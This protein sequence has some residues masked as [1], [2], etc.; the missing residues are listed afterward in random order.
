MIRSIF[1]L[2]GVF[3]LAAF[4]FVQ[5]VSAQTTVKTKKATV[6]M[7]G[8]IDLTMVYRNS[9]Y[10]TSQKGDGTP[11]N[12]GI[13]FIDPNTSNAERVSGTTGSPTGSS[14]Y[15]DPNLVLNFTIDV[16]ENVRGVIELRTPF[17]NPDAGGKN[18]TPNTGFF[19]GFK[20]RTLEVKQLYAE[21][22]EIFSPSADEPGQG[23]LLR[24]GIFDFRKDLR[25]NGNSF[26]IDT[27]GSEHPFDSLDGTGA[28]PGYSTGFADSTEAA[29]AY[30]Q[31]KFWLFNI[32]AFFLNLDESYNALGLAGSG[33][34]RRD[35]LFWGGSADVLFGSE[36]KFGKL[37]LTVF[38]LM[39]TS[40]THL[41]TEGAG[42]VVYPLRTEE[43]NLIELFGEVYFQQGAYARNAS[44]TGS[45]VDQKEA[46]ALQFGLKGS[47]PPITIMEDKK[48]IPYIEGTYV[49]VSGDDDSLDD[50]NE[51]FVSLENNNRTIVV[52]NGYYGYDID[53]NYRGVRVAGGFHLADFNFEILYAYFEL[54]DN[55]GGR[56][57]GGGSRS[58][59]IGD[60]LDLSVWYDYS[61]NLK[62]GFQTGWLLDSHALGQ[63]RTTQITLFSIVL[64]F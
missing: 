50:E 59:K 32:D 51:N 48:F 47:L 26:V 14:V 31:Y 11:G 35:L 44:V 46:F 18:T 56:V 16:G 4:L 9:K 17:V 13:P 53:T 19:A 60:E 7:S 57:A 6:T 36:G 22:D 40:N 23:L 29:G 63:S 43:V 20:D 41:V 38:D 49:E 5:P 39:N 28:V 15:L 25:G 54:Q 58:A 10:Y 33:A 2:V 1:T 24:A 42:I 55:T 52:E 37:F 3:V 12:T 61:A 30:A 27:A 8:K 62:L 21:I 34:S 45:D 64:D